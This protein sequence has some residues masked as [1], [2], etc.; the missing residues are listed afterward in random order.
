VGSEEAPV[1]E[2]RVEPG[3]AAA[4]SLADIK[5]V[6]TTA[7]GEHRLCLL[8]GDRRLTLGPEFRYSGSRMCVR[9]LSLFGQVERVGDV[10]PWEASGS[11]PAV[12]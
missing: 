12:D 6:A 8:V 1:I 3:A 4:S 7:P 2:M 5:I 9:M 10:E 11:P